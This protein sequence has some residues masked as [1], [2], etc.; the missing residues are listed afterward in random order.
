MKISQVLI[1]VGIFLITVFF[2]FSFKESKGCGQLVIDS[3]EVI[4]GLNVPPQLDANCYFDEKR[5]LRVGLYQL[6]NP[7]KYIRENGFMRMEE[8]AL[9]DLFWSIELLKNN[10]EEFPESNPDWYALQWVKRGHQWQCI[11]ERTSGRMWM[12]VLWD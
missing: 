11:I 2:G 3:N 4:T 7:K 1:L 8:V 12:E 9:G 10:M 5:Q 6:E